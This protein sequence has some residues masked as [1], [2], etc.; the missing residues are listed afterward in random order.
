MRGTHFEFFIDGPP[1]EDR[2]LGSQLINTVELPEAD[3]PLEAIED[4]FPVL[5]V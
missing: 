4:S 2:E 5:A 1:H 3:M